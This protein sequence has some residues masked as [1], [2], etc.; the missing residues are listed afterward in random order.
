VGIAVAIMGLAA[1]GLYLAGARDTR[2]YGSV[3]GLLGLGAWAVGAMSVL[4]N[5]EATRSFAHQYP[6]SVS[7]GGSPERARQLMRDALGAYGFLIRC[8]LLGAILMGVGALL[9]FR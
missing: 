5:W 7:H 6:S 4:G 3:F 1:L 8:S 9:Y 2:Q